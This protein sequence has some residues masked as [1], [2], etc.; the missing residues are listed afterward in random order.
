MQRRAR[1]ALPRTAR[2]LRSSR[3]TAATEIRAACCR[4]DGAVAAR[5]R[6]PRASTELVDRATRRGRYQI[7]HAMDLE[8]LEALALGD[9]GG[10]LAQLLPGSEDHD[11]FRCIQAQHAGALDDAEAIVT[12]W[13]ERHG[14]SMRLETL[15]T[16]QLLY[17]LGAGN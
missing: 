12:A 15:R 17:R 2:R 14:Q 7:L 8:I 16:R 10:A 11:Y 5:R 1:R 4:P 9:R 6:L 3:A 13:P